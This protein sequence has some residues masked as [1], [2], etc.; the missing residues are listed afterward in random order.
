VFTGGIVVES[1]RREDFYSDITFELFIVGAIDDT[2][3]TGAD[4][5]QDAVVAECL[6]NHEEGNL[7]LGGPF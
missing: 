7:L 3:P 5:F 4:L 6:A 2:H 1:T